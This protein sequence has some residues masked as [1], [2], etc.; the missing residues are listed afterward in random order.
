MG[1]HGTLTKVLLLVP[2]VQIQIIFYRSALKLATLVYRVLPHSSNKK[3][4]NKGPANRRKHTQIF[5][6]HTHYNL[7]HRKFCIKHILAGCPGQGVQYTAGC[8]VV[9]PLIQNTTDVCVCVYIRSTPA[10]NTLCICQ[11]MKQL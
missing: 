1:T 4:N 6:A 10:H 2:F 9:M 3:Q 11:E 5:Y 7:V 8:C